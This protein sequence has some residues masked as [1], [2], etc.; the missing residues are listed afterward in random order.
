MPQSDDGTAHFTFYDPERD[1]SFNWDGKS[2]VI[3]VVHDDVVIGT[4]KVE[5][6]IGVASA[7]SARWLEW[8]Q[9]VCTN[10][11]RLKVGD[12]EGTE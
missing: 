9:L 4:F 8:F 3:E 12:K 2:P 10:Y 7:G 6:R 1:F 5:P 11:V